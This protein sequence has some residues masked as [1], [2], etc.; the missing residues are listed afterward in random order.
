MVFSDLVSRIIESISVAI[1]FQ[2]INKK[3]KLLRFSLCVNSKYGNQVL[4]VSENAVL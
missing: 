1:L 3:E 2:S 4:V